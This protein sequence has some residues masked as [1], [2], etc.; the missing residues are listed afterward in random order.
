MEIF[1]TGIPLGATEF[2]L[3]DVLT[4]VLHGPSFAHY[5]TSDRPFNFIVR[6]FEPKKGARR[7]RGR[8]AI[9][10]RTWRD[11]LLL[12]PS[13][14]IGEY[15]LDSVNCCEDF[16][17]PVIINEVFG[18]RLKFRAGKHELS[19][20]DLQR[21]E[22]PYVDAQALR[23]DTERRAELSK[24]MEISKV[25]FGWHCH[26]DA[27]SIEA[28][29]CSIDPPWSISFDVKHRRIVI[30]NNAGMRVIIR[31]K[32][33]RATLEG[34]KC[35]L[36]LDQPPIFD[37]QHQPNRNPN[38]DPNIDPD[39]HA[40]KSDRNVNVLN[41]NVNPIVANF[42]FGFNFDD[43]WRDIQLEGDLINDDYD[44]G[45]PEEELRDRLKSPNPH[46][47]IFAYL[48][49]ICFSFS[50]SDQIGIFE[51]KARTA[52]LSIETSTAHDLVKRGHFSAMNVSKFRR[53]L[54]LLPYDIAFQLDGL[55]SRCIFHPSELLELVDPICAAIDEFGSEKTVILTRSLESQR[56]KYPRL[57]ARELFYGL[58]QEI[59]DSRDYQ[60][61][62]T[63]SLRR[64]RVSVASELFYCHRATITPT[65][66]ILAGPLPD[67]T[68]RVIRQFSNNMSN[69]LR[70]EFREEDRHQIRQDE[71]VNTNTF[72]DERFGSILHDG[73][74]VAGRKFELLGWSSSA[75]R[76]HAVW[77]IHPFEIIQDSQPVIVDGDYIRNSLGDFSK[78]IQCPARYG[79]RIGQAFSATEPTIDIG[80]HEIIQ[81]GDKE[82]NTDPPS[83]FTDGVS[84]MSPE[85]AAEIW[86]IMTNKQSKRRFKESP[87]PSAFQIRFGGAKGVFCVCSSMKG[88]RHIA[89]R[90]SMSKF[91]STDSVVEV[92]KAFDR[93]MDTFLNRPLVMLLETLGVPLKPLMEL[94][95]QALDRTE[96]KSW[97]CPTMAQLLEESGLGGAFALPSIFTHL[98]PRPGEVDITQR[99]GDPPSSMVAFLQ[100]VIRFSVNHILWEIK[101]KARIKVPDAWTLV[102]VADEHDYL[103]EGE[104]YACIRKLD[105]EIIYIEGP[106]LIS[107]SPTVHPG[108]A[109]MVRA[110]GRP[111][112]FGSGVGLSLLFNCVVFS[113]RG[114]RSL[115]SMLAG[116]DLDG[117][118]YALIL[119]PNLHIVEN[120]PPEEATVA[121]VLKNIGRSSNV[122]DLG[123]FVTDYIKNDMLGVISTRL[124]R[125]ADKAEK[126]MEDEACL[127]L[128]RLH[129][130][131]VDFPKTGIPVQFHEMPRAPKGLPDWD[132]G[133]ANVDAES[134]SYYRS[135]RH[136]GYLYREVKLPAVPEA[137]RTARQQLRLRRRRERQGEREMYVEDIQGIFESSKDENPVT[138]TL[139]QKIG[140]TFSVGR[141]ED[142]ESFDIIEE[143]MAI[144]QQYARELE[145]ISSAR[146]VVAS[147]P[148]SE[149]EIVAGSIVATSSQYIRKGN[150]AAMRR[151]STDLCVMIRDAIKGVHLGERKPSDT[152]VLRRAWNAWKISVACEDSFGGK[153][154]GLL[155]CSIAFGC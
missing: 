29:L 128:A 63:S 104:I 91:E 59:D 105:G 83:V 88:S 32:A 53:S 51:R 150:I 140:S 101:Y 84:P 11:G 103:R 123:D 66:T 54:K 81:I 154:F 118:I 131:A 82:S 70:V 141:E 121:K 96:E 6:I 44:F 73:L 41:F 60:P 14:A 97:S 7:G 77:F 137:K 116:G 26:D 133:Q 61:H 110:I 9:G 143:M 95:R 142:G 31:F 138:Q 55:L 125:T 92:S 94:Q 22:G 23:E 136:L 111:P 58:C 8:L 100:R 57:P 117:D 102:G 108:D 36:W 129:S 113:C 21:L 112:H 42:D 30:E 1:I 5:S 89:I 68:N 76:E 93:P 85:L 13:R 153:S 2:H 147:R 87:P 144:F 17:D 98:S 151:E 145:I 38:P 155:A 3:H 65:S 86:S 152:S 148:L 12:V 79:A 39:Q 25:E 135:E 126:C 4:P 69:F 19:E 120:K 109:R 115:P 62:K 15:F 124:L 52:R 46:C 107:R 149:E 10:G 130:I 119:D 33:V 16:M 35:F 146:P 80:F 27:I 20:R 45:L 99:S 71:E 132:S 90:P 50:H 47:P 139:V 106:V 74:T 34:E 127:T 24:L 18:Q 67:E 40:P 48:R 28:S 75:L 37:Q 49:I 43:I 64:G 72:I 114:K 122:R 134:D 78:V 56:G